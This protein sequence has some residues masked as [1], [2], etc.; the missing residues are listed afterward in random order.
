MALDDVKL[1][2]ASLTM[3]GTLH[4]ITRRDTDG[5]EVWSDREAHKKIGDATFLLD[6]A[7]QLLNAHLAAPIEPAPWKC[8][9]N[10]GADQAQHS[11][12][13]GCIDLHPRGLGGT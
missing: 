4:A 12:Y 11:Q 8:S 10:C 13:G 2:I 3:I 9:R 7:K 5:R 6:S 1:A